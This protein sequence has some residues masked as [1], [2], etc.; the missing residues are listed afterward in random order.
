M[1]GRQENLARISAIHKAM[2]WSALGECPAGMENC[3]L[4][5]LACELKGRMAIEAVYLAHDPPPQVILP[6]GSTFKDGKVELP[7]G[8][9]FADLQFYKPRPHRLEDN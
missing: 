2:R 7:E 3:T 6:P 1:N 5:G 9:T 8:K 4:G